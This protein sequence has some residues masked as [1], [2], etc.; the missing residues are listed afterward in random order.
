MKY[1]TST[2]GKDTTVNYMNGKAFK[3]SDKEELVFAIVTTFME[4]NYYESSNARLVRIKE[5]IKKVDPVF[6][7]K[8]AI[9]TRKEFNMRSAFHVL[10]G[11]LAK[12][13]K[14][15]SLVQNT[16]L[17]GYTRPDDLIEIVAYLGKPIPN[18]VKKA[19]SKILSNMNAYQLGKYQAKG[20]KVSMV[21]LFNLTHPKPNKE[22][23]DT[24]KK[25]LAG[26]LEAP[27][28]WEVRLSTEKDKAK[29]WKELLNTNKL[30]YM[31]TLRNLRNMIKQADLDT[32][33]L[34]CRK[35]S[36]KDEV[37]KSK[38]L[39]F[40]FLSAWKAVDEAKAHKEIM[41]EK[42]LDV[43]EMIKQAITTAINH[44]IDNIP[45]LEGKTLILSDNSGSMRGDGGGASL[46]SA[47][48]KRTT[49]DIANLFAVLYWSKADN[50]LVGSFGDTLRHPQLDRTKDVFEN[51]KIMNK[52]A[53][54]V[55]GGTETGIFVM[56]EKLIANKEMVDR[57]IIFSDCQVGTECNWYDTGHRR[58][59]DFNRLFQKYR[60]INPDVKVYCVDLR[61]YGNRMIKDGIVLL[62]GWSDKIFDLM[63]A[64]E[65]KE[66]LVKW[67]ENY[68]SQK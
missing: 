66:G 35:I 45:L 38:Q 24:I 10:V 28:T 18:S 51:F 40:R 20:K 14:G 58:G 59:S 8:L 36:D 55:G 61:G 31:A 34:A 60:A 37:K 63:E 65:K 4:D 17:Q 15:D 52:D 30:G 62:A 9:V 57:I 11:E 29:V 27:E 33:K 13:H 22:N 54:L 42:D 5:L 53:S 49:A 56:F 32:L 41:F 50:T 46:I 43:A 3:Q 7:S 67:I 39:P 68:Q 21:D 6:V 1:S 19:I 47:M 23:A 44:S 48:S 25:F 12:L 64:I 26:N 2:K 16:I